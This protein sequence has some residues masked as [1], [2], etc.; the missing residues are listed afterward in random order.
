MLLQD[1]E[2]TSAGPRQPGQDLLALAIIN[3]LDVGVVLSDGG[4]ARVRFANPEG[5][6]ALAA[7]GG[8]GGALPAALRA[9][10]AAR[11]A[12]ELPTRRFTRAAEVSSP[13]GQ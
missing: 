12:G 5:L 8:G 10:L 4:L 11:T 13:S 3:A 2:V 9:V 6:R 1:V 7:L